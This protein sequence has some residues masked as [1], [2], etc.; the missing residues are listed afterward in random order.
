ML[1]TTVHQNP[2]TSQ[3]TK[4]VFWKWINIGVSST[5]VRVWYSVYIVF[6]DHNTSNSDM[7]DMAVRKSVKTSLWNLDCIN[8][9]ISIRH[10]EYF[11]CITNY[12]HYIC[13]AFM[14]FTFQTDKKHMFRGFFL[15]PD[16]SKVWCAVIGASQ[17]CFRNALASEIVVRKYHS[18]HSG[19]TCNVL[20]TENKNSIRWMNFCAISI[21]SFQDARPG[22]AHLSVW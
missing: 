14:F 17:T 20:A 13:G 5:S 2:S 11:P 3:D 15:C 21:S 8:D 19:G 4:D 9:F 1:P 12:M 6:P 16:A 18:E 22:K 7:Q 10:I